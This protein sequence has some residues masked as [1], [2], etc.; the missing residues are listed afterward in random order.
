VRADGLPVLKVFDEVPDVAH[1]SIFRLVD[2]AADLPIAPKQT[3]DERKYRCRD[4]EQKQSLTNIHVWLLSLRTAALPI[5]SYQMCQAFHASLR[6]FA[7]VIID[8]MLQN[9]DPTLNILLRQD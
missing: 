7:R 9:P 4:A 2:I 8:D 6:E 5:P 1:K 3:A